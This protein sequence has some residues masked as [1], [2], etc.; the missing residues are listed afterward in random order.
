MRMGCCFWTSRIDGPPWPDIV[1]IKGLD[2]WHQVDPSITLGSMEPSVTGSTTLP[3]LLEAWRSERQN[4]GTRTKNAAKQTKR[5]ST[6]FDLHGISDVRNMTRE[7]LVEAFNAERENGA[8]L[9]TRGTLMSMVHSFMEWC[10]AAGHANVNP[11]ISIGRPKRV[12]GGAGP[13][14]RRGVRPLTNAEAQAWLTFTLAD[15]ASDQPISRTHR[16]TRIA[17]A[18]C[19]GGRLEQIA[20]LR[21]R[22]ID[23]LDGPKPAVIYDA[24]QSKNGSGWKV[25]LPPMAVGLLKAYRKSTLVLEPDQQLFPARTKY[26]NKKVDRDMRKAGVMRKR[27]G[28]SASFHSL[29]KTYCRN[30]VHSGVPVSVAQQLMQH[31]TLA[32]TLE[33]YAECQDE[34]KIEAAGRA[35]GYVDKNLLELVNAGFSEEK[36]PDFQI[37]QPPT[38]LEDLTEGGRMAEST[39]AKTMRFT[40]TQHD[41]LS[42]PPCEGQRQ[43]GLGRLPATLPQGGV[44]ESLVGCRLD[45]TDREPPTAEANVSNRIGLGGFEP[46]T[47]AGVG[48]LTPTELALINALRRERVLA[49]QLA[50]A[51]AA[52]RGVRP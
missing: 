33:V 42:T 4:A 44:A 28:R 16:S 22:D 37:G 43:H 45:V 50:E 29:R 49:G 40:N 51:R 36:V 32:M 20:N 9:K 12:R 52:L 7:Q 21:W 3:A 10:K 1:Q 18:W 8:G 13:T 47:A 41:S 27:N 17:L 23:D 34:D 5:L 48:G 31:K 26:D 25:P 30:L 19:T 24:D 14:A 38:A 46:P 15:E 11:M 2:G 35:A 6:F 39:S